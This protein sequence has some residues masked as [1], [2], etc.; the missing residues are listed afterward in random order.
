MQAA[1]RSRLVLRGCL[2]RRR[3]DDRYGESDR[4]GSRVAD[5]LPAAAAVGEH[6][7]GWTCGAAIC[8]ATMAASSPTPLRSDDLRL[9]RK[10]TP[11]K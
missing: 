6:A 5:R 8:R 11:T 3:T 4:K 10:C 9:R 1:T 7:A 2:A